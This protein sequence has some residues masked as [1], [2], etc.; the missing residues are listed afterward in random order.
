MN[1]KYYII[2]GTRSEYNEFI[3]RKSHELFSMGVDISLS[4]F[5]YVVNS[6][7]LRG[8]ENPTG[9]F[10]GTWRERPDIKPLMQELLARKRGFQNMEVLRKNFEDIMRVS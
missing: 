6:D 7:V 1:G 9:W 4:H 5:V 2:T 3:L 10:Y 8:I